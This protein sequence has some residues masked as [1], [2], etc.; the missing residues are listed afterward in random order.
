MNQYFKEL[1]VDI[2][3]HQRRVR[4]GAT[5]RKSKHRGGSTSLHGSVSAGSLLTHSTG[6]NDAR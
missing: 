1:F 2:D 5:P 4:N 6:L 3:V